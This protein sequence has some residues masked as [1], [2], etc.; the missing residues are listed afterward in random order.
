M[1]KTTMTVLMV[2]S[3]VLF[4]VGSALIAA[5][6]PLPPETLTMT[7]E[8][9]GYKGR[10]AGPVEFNHKKHAE[11]YN[12]ACADCHHVYEDGKNIWKEGD[13]VQTCDSCHEVAAQCLSPELPGLP[14]GPQKRGET[15]GTHS[16][17]GV[18]P[19]G[20]IVRTAQQASF[21]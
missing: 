14:Q 4:L 10:P 20:K 1:K 6:A 11:D 15:Y 21:F 16:L 9:K 8:G 5:E 7:G 12:I 3:A 2:I 17:Y 18:P 19:A 13:P